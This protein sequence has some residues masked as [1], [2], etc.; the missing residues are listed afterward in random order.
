MAGESKDAAV[1]AELG[2]WNGPL[3]QGGAGCWA[4]RGALAYRAGSLAG[5]SPQARGHVPERPR[6]S[7]AAARRQHVSGVVVQPVPG[8]A[9]HPARPHPPFPE[10]L[11]GAQCALH[12]AMDT[13]GAECE[14]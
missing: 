2:E 13:V 8:Q 7:A 12:G 6:L 1:Q 4:G 9:L 3:L 11:S 5:I 14:R 10:L